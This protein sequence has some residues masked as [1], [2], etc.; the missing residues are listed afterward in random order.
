MFT[1][2]NGIPVLD[3]ALTVEELS[4]RDGFVCQFPDCEEPLSLDQDDKHYVSIDHIYPQVRARRDGWTYEQINDISN[5]QLMGRSCNG[6]KG[7]ALYKDDGTLDLVIVHRTPKMPRPEN[8]DICANGRLLL[9]G[10]VCEYCGTD[11]QPR[12]F[13]AYAQKKPK[14]CSH[15]WINPEDHC[16]MCVIGHIERAPASRTVFGVIENDE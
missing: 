2:V 11:P 13:P 8:C 3:R 5:L 9:K 12:S 16:W 15:G 14:D 1:E 7:D 6:K 4:K 10:E